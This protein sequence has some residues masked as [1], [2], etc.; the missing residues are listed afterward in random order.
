MKQNEPDSPETLVQAF[1]HSPE[2]DAANWRGT[3]FTYH[4]PKAMGK[5]LPGIGLGFENFEAGKKVFD[6]WINRLGRVDACE[7]LRISIVEGPV[8]SGAE[9]YTVF[10]S[11]NPFHT[12][13]RK[14]IEDPDFKPTR[15]IRMS[16]LNRMTPDPSS[17]HLRL[18]KI[19]FAI[20]GRY[21]LFPAHLVGSEIGNVDLTRCIEKQE[22][23]LLHTSSLQPQDLEYEAI[24]S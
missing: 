12:I 13:Q 14:Q 20:V 8:A 4:Y 9:G 18:F 22:L 19:H 16:R 6:G 3:V 23:N 1:T 24:T 17:P 11:S 7:E 15:F 10:I 2:W 21:R 5:E